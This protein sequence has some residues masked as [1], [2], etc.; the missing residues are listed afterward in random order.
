[1]FKKSSSTSPIRI[2]VAATPSEWLPAKILEFSILR[3]TKA[4]VSVKFLYQFHKTIPVPAA[5]ENRQRTPFSFQRFLIPELCNFSGKAIYLDSDMLVFRD[6]QALWNHDFSNCS[7]QSVKSSGQNRPPQ[8]GV[9]LL[10]CSNLNWQINQIINQ[11]DMGALHYSDL[12]FE[13]KIVDKVGRDIDANWNSLESYSA[14]ETALLHY[15]DMETQ[16]WTYYGKNPL[17]HIWLNYLKNALN[18]GFITER[19]LRREIKKGHVR[20]SLL[21]QILNP[22]SEDMALKHC[23]E[24]FVAP[25]KFPGGQVPTKKNFFTQLKINLI[26]L[27]PPYSIYQK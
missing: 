17:A 1:M 18:E 19:E 22:L 15:T 4:Q 2:F 24:N 21:P 13:M 7:L 10:N 12:M 9:M 6:I 14:E 8:F 3:N 23:D 11:L 16:P 27:L 25:H 20:P 26:R 5:P